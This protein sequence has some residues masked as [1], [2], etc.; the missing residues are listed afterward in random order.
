MPQSY[1]AHLLSTPM[2][3]AFASWSVICKKGLTNTKRAARRH[4]RRLNSLHMRDGVSFQEFVSEILFLCALLAACHSPVSDRDKLCVLCMG[5]TAPF[6]MTRTI[7]ELNEHT[8]F[9]RAVDMFTAVRGYR[10]GEGSQCANERQATQERL[11]QKEKPTLQS[12][13]RVLP[14]LLRCDQTQVSPHRGG[15]LAQAWET[16]KPVP[17]GC[18]TH[19]PWAESA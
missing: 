14:F 4:K 19:A 13:G 11:S 7:L 18:C 16:A 3:D 17:E 10:P 8:T 9:E 15:L 5:V 6:F 1:T 2:G 12:F